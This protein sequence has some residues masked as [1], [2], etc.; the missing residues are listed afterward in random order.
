MKLEQDEKVVQV[1]N[2]K[3]PIKETGEV[4]L[5][6]TDKAT[7]AT[8]AGAEFSLYDKSGAELQNG[9]TTDENGEL[10]I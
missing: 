7:G 4:H 2:E 6:K 10:T 5:V 3:M 9:L 8:L 1:M